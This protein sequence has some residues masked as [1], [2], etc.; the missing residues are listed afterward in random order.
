M[1]LW[2]PPSRTL[3]FANNLPATPS[4]TTFGTRA[5]SS[6]S[7][8]TKGSWAQVVASLPFD[9]YGFWLVVGGSASATTRT[10]QL[11]DIGFGTTV[12]VPDLLTGWRSP[13]S[14]Y[15]PFFIPK[16]TQVQVRI[17]ALIA[18]DT[19]D[20]MF[21]F[22][23]GPAL[24]PHAPYVGCDAY[25]VAAASSSGTSHTA[26]NSG[27]ESSFASL[28]STLSRDYSGV[29]LLVGGIVSGTT[30]SALAYHFEIGYSSTALAEWYLQ[31]STS[32]A[33]VGP[34]PALIAEVPLPSGTQLQV[35]GECSGTAQA[36]DVA[37]YCFY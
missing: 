24:P 2:L 15:F 32:E 10:D 26:G 9:A 6:A 8:H 35:R 31:T 27:A 4:T 33:V 34:L 5:T 12:V 18:S 37:A 28:G 14:L 19:L 25:G 21:F 20:C 17:Q 16:G 11:L 23:G 13:N 30:M 7:I 22:L 29:L 36:L 3:L 1:S